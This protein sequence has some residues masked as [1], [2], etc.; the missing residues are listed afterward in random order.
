MTRQD[1]GLHALLVGLVA[2][3]FVLQPVADM[4]WAP[5]WLPLL[6][7]LGTVAAGV[8][9]R[10]TR[11]AWGVAACGLALAGALGASTEVAAGI[12][13]AAALLL[14]S[15]GLLRQVVAPGRVTA[16]RIE[17][18]VALYLL[19]ALAFRYFSLVTQTS[20]GFG[21]IVP[22]APPART[23]APLQAVMGQVFIAVLL[24]RLV[25]LELAGRGAGDRA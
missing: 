13:G 18:A 11:L 15:I 6:V 20:T 1:A 8:L 5:S 7:T 24:A 23:L 9:A 25:S 22:T 2:G 21:D 3:L 19:I 17:G 4:G 12:A 10:A 16:R 14:L